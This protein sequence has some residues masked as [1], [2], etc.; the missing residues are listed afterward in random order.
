M[1]AAATTGP[2]M[3][4][5]TWRA[6]EQREEQDRAARERIETDAVRQA[7]AQIA[8][9]QRAKRSGTLARYRPLVLQLADGVALSETQAVE[10]MGCLHELAI[11]SKDIDADVLAVREHR[12]ALARLA[13]LETQYAKGPTIEAARAEHDRLSAESKASRERYAKLCDGAFSAVE[14]I[15]Y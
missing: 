6:L 8:G 10:L 14:N 15:G 1:S 9:I 4:A 11:D 3:P 7:T 12:A 13:D 5:S 2:Q